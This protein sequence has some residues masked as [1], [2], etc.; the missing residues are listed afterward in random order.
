MKTNLKCLDHIEPSPKFKNQKECKSSTQRYNL[1]SMEMSWY[2]IMGCGEKEMPM[3]KAYPLEDAEN[4]CL[5]SR[6][7][8]FS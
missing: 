3:P 2:G 4:C 1:A 6:F 7:L 8:L 5:F